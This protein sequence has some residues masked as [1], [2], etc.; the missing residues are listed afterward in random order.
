M[1]AGGGDLTWN[2]GLQGI[3]TLALMALALG[4][5]VQILFLRRSLWWVGIAAAVVAFVV[6]VFVS[7]VWFGWATEKDL[8]PN[9]DG[10]SFD[11]TLLG[12]VALAVIA[13][14]ARLALGGRLAQPAGR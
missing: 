12:L 13:V 4:A 10:L 3:G 6:G 9:I 14:V 11:E 1:R 7:E 8:Q 5:F 2:L